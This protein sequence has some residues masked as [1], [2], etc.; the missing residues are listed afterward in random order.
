MKKKILLYLM[1]ICI[2]LVGCS[3][4]THNLTETEIAKI[5]LANER[6]DSEQLRT[7]GNLFTSGNQAFSMIKEYSCKFNQRMKK[8]KTELNVNVDGTRYTWS[9]AVDYTNFLSYFDSYAIGIEF[10]AEKGSNLIDLAK[11]TITTV[12]VWVKVDSSEQILLLVDKDSETIMS[13]S[14][15]QYEICRRYQNLLGQ[16]VFEM[17]I[18]NSETNAK[19]RMT[20]IPGLRYEYTSIIDEHMLVI[21]ASKEKG[22]WD[23]MSTSYYEEYDKDGMTFSNLVMKDEAIYET[24]YTITNYGDYIDNQYGD[25]KLISSDGKNDL[26]SISSDSIS[27]FTTGMNNLNCFYI[28]ALD[29]EVAD[30]NSVSNP[31]DYKLLYLGDGSNR[32]YFTVQ[33]GDVIAK[34]DNGKKLRKGDVL[35]DGNVEV[36]GTMIHPIGEVDFYGE[37]KLTF[38]DNNLESMFDKL[39][40]IMNEYDFTLKDDLNDIKDAA[41]YASYDLLDFSELYLWQG[42]HINSFEGIFNSIK[43]EEE[44]INEFV[45][46]YNI[47]K[48]NQVIKS[49]KQMALDDSYYFSNL[50]IISLGNV[51]NENNKITISDLV[52]EVEDCKLFTKNTNY[53]I[54]FAFAKESNGIY[55]NLFTLPFDN[56]TIKLYEGSSVT[57]KTTFELTQNAVLE[58]PALEAGEYVLVAYVAVADEGIRITNPV[59]IKGNVIDIEINQDGYVNIL[60]NGANN[61]VIITSTVTPLINITLNGTYTYNDLHLV[62]ESYAYKYGSPLDGEIEKENNSNWHVVSNDGMLSSGTYRLKYHNN[63]FNQDSYVI[64]TLK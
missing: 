25:I 12:D 1:L 5:L 37:I 61:T 19:S 59:A 14:D 23:I 41:I 56:P 51:S 22:Y 47:Y 6:L 36:Y 52:V 27:I 7:D 40:D 54:S 35:C 53:Q 31:E 30:A 18:E 17:F 57:N 13:R 3:G 34:F 4:K 38:A 48:D 60:T 42:N 43:T 33:Y 15:E 49:S 26:L 16:N 2:L 21:V 44:L 45:N 39:Q 20:F 8:N 24:T 29:S 64:V 32:Q 58:V 63:S 10:S 55:S 9:D 28:D 46:L 62:L 50:N 11:S